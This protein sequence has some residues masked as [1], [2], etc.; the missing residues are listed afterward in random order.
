[1]QADFPTLN[2][3]QD[4]CERLC[5]LAAQD[6]QVAIVQMMGEAFKLI[7]T[8]RTVQGG[9][10]LQLQG[11]LASIRSGRPEEAAEFIERAIG[12]GQRWASTPAG[13]AQ[14]FP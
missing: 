4:L 6:D 8:A 2:S 7:A 1:M 5:K 13:T 9:V 14:A 3:L 12:I 11:A 10:H